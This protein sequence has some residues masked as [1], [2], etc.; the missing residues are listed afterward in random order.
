MRGVG[1][2]IIIDAVSD[3]KSEY[4]REPTDEEKARLELDAKATLSN[5]F[6]DRKDKE[7]AIADAEKKNLEFLKIIEDGNLLTA[8]RYGYDT[9]K[10]SYKDRVKLIM[11]LRNKVLVD[12]KR[13]MNIGGEDSE[14]EINVYTVSQLISEFLGNGEESYNEMLVQL[15]LVEVFDLGSIAGTYSVPLNFT[16]TTL[17]QTHVLEENKLTTDGTAMVGNANA[18]IDISSDGMM[19]IYYTIA[20]ASTQTNSAEYSEMTDVYTDSANYE[21]TESFKNMKI[22][23]KPGATTQFSDVLGDYTYSGFEKHKQGS[24]DVSPSTIS[25][26]LEGV[27]AKISGTTVVI[28]GRT[29]INMPTTNVGNISQKFPATFELIIGSNDE[30]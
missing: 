23:V 10:I 9:D 15:K 22:N 3:F 20:I 16:K 17:N 13:K 4:G 8:N 5:E 18:T 30:E 27:T 26:N 6:K 19:S 28:T 12:T 21:V 29:E 2:Q 7:A 25:G 14:T 24:W 1:R 11:E